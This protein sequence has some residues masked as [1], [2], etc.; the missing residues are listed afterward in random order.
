MT[1]AAE[2]EAGALLAVL[3]R[4]RRTFAWKTDGLDDGPAHGDRREH[5]EPGDLIANM[6]LVEA[7]WLAVTT[8]GEG[9]GPPWESVD[10]DAEP[11]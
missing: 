3:E 5:H 2:T 1:R 4:N 6:A 7:D 9:Y 8:A 11:N 10:V